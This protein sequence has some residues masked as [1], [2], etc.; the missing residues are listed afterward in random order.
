MREMGTFR[1]PFLV[2][3]EF[4]GLYLLLT[5]KYLGALFIIDDI[6][7]S[8]HCMRVPKHFHLN[9]VRRKLATNSEEN[10]PLHC[11]IML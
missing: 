11:P 9:N 7:E 4:I 2:R 10:S 1:T 6:N 5:I 8:I 3:N